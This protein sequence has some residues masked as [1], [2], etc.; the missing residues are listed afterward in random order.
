MWQRY[1]ALFGCLGLFAAG[2]EIANP[3]TDPADEAG[4]P[5]ANVRNFHGLE[6]IGNLADAPQANG[7]ADLRE[8]HR[9][10]TLNFVTSPGFGMERMPRTPSGHSTS[11]TFFLPIV[12]IKDRPDLSPPGQQWVVK[13]KSLIG[14]MYNTEGQAYVPNVF[15]DM[16][17]GKG[18]PP[19]PE[20][21]RPMDPFETLAVRGLKAG[22]EL[23]IE[24]K[25]GSI[26]MMGAMYAEKSC[27][28]CHDVKE[29]TLL[30]ALSY[31][32]EK[33]PDAGLPVLP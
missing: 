10:G 6:S 12:D 8:A 17:N 11:Q 32:L 18:V 21:L 9:I 27:A 24:P 14:F 3:S 7:G 20:V 23:L 22:H 5:P 28:K 31:T 29:G 26:R 25:P 13:N 19:K 30:G 33:A 16:K 1:L 2:C 4:T 15:L